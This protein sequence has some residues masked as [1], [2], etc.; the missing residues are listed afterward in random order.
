M[1]S[2]FSDSSI[3]SVELI[4]STSATPIEVSIPCTESMLPP[5]P[6][7]SCAAAIQYRYAWIEVIVLYS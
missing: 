7:A 3:A 5:I 1:R 2:S 6:R 4:P